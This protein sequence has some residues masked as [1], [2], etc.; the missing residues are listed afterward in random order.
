MD[1]LRID[2]NEKEYDCDVLLTYEDGASWS[3]IIKIADSLKKEGKSV[4]VQK[5]NTGA[6]RY[7]ETLK[8]LKGGETVNG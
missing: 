5:N 1:G 4:N 2:E 6:L 3:D 8:V 7:K